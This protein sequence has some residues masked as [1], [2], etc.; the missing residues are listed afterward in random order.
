M[1]EI[2][3]SAL[4]KQCLDRRIGDIEALRGEIKAWTED[5]DRKGVKV[6]WRFTTK[7]AREKLRRL[8]LK[9]KLPV[10]YTLSL[11][12]SHLH[13]VSER[14][15]LLDLKLQWMPNKN[16]KSQSP[17]KQNVAKYFLFDAK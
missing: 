16:I 5:R 6:E 17:H 4:S 7:D 2:E 3:F 14:N 13:M 8:M 11:P 9:I 1:A 12:F 15:N 10:R